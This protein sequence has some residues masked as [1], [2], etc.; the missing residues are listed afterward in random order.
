M[1]RVMDGHIVRVALMPG[2]QEQDLLAGNIDPA[3]W[4]QAAQRDDGAP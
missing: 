2:M 1:G 3:M 4:L